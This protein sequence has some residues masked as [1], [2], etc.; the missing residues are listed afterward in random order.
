MTPLSKAGVVAGSY[1]YTN[2][3]YEPIPC[4]NRLI[5]TTTDWLN[6][7]FV[8]TQTSQQV[9]R[10]TGEYPDGSQRILDC[11]ATQLIHID[12]TYPFTYEAQELA[13]GLVLASPILPDYTRKPKLKIVSVERTERFEDMWYINEGYR[14]IVNGFMLG[15][16]ERRG[17]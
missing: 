16:K 6:A 17:F 14:T 15:T 4:M 8:K 11:C 3:G 1:M 12:G 13:E 10:I 5:W 7:Y 9:W 2:I